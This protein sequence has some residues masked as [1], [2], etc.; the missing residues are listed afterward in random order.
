MIE[1]KTIEEKNKRYRPYMVLSISNLLF[2]S[3]DLSDDYKH[4]IGNHFESKGSSLN[5]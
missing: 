2:F 5:Q 3:H 4:E 1:R